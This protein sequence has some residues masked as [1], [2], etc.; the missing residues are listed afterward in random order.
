MAK[1]VRARLLIEQSEASDYSRAVKY[2][3]E[4]TWTPAGFIVFDIAVT[5]AVQTLSVATLFAAIDKV[6]VVNN[7]ASVAFKLTVTVDGSAITMDLAAG[8]AVMLDDV[9][10]VNFTVDGDAAASSAQVIVWGT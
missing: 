8:E 6:V 10:L 1:Y 2:S 7:H 4:D 9:G 3:F 5:N